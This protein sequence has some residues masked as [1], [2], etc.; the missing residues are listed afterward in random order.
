MKKYLY[1]INSQFIFIKFINLFKFF[2]LKNFRLV[3]PPYLPITMDVEPTTGCN[4]RCTM[5][6]VSSPGFKSQNMNLETFKNFINQNKQL[7]KIKLQ[8]M[9]EPTV[10]NKFL[11]MID[12]ANQ[13]GIVVEFTTNGSLL[14]QTFIHNL[15]QKKISKI[16]ISIDGATKATFEKI[17][18]KSNFN[19]IINNV[20]LLVKLSKR[21][22]LRPEICAW[23]VVQKDNIEEFEK[24]FFLC[25]EIGFD[26]LSY[27]FHISNWGKQ[28]WQNINKNKEINLNTK[29]DFIRDIKKNNKF[30]TKIN[31]FTENLLSFKKKC[32]W[33]VRSSYID[34]QGFVSPCC[35]IGDSKV[36]NFG[37]IN[38]NNFKEIWNSTNY[39]KFREDINNN[40]L[41]SFCKNC[42][43]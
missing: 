20:K 37:N 33:P 36:I 12:V 42:Y 19:E 17:R 15:L 29:L 11:E 4:F 18:L 22:F 41:P 34:N 35:I 5:C 31:M 28:E 40:K 1:F 43:K 23:T 6:Q 27:Q 38:Q 8:G 24:I 9:G 14:S 16:T 32:K 30:K 26:S 10:N 21:N 39:I 25:N 13:S 7:L 2:L 3:N